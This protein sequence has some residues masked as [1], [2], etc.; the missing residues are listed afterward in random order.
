MSKTRY[1]RKGTQLNKGSLPIYEVDLQKIDADFSSYVRLRDK[2]YL[3]HYRL[4]FLFS[5]IC[6]VLS[7]V[8]IIINRGL[9]LFAF[10]WIFILLYSC[11]SIVFL[12]L[13]IKQQKQQL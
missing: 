8:L 9:I 1:A 12:S 13:G 4:L 10:F 2:Y 11:I 6:I 5:L 3:K 7:I